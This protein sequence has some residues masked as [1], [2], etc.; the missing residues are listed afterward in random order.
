MLVRDIIYPQEI[1]LKVVI[2]PTEVGMR[3]LGMMIG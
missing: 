1:T 2:G 3:R